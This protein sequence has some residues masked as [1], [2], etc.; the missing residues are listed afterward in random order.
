[1]SIK[2]KFP[3][4]VKLKHLLKFDG[5]SSKLSAFDISVRDTL[6]SADYLCFRGGTVQFLDNMEEW[7][8]VRYNI[9]NAKSNYGFGKRVCAEIAK[10]LSGNAAEW[11]QLYRSDQANPNPNCWKLCNTKESKPASVIEISLFNLLES[12]F[13]GESDAQIAD[14]ELQKI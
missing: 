3:S 11:W 9:S 5:N 12:V 7:S 13:P 8:F 4:E 2:I 6:E 14:Q 10:Y 1:M